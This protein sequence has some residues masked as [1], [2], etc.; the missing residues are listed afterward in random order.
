MQLKFVRSW[1]DQRDLKRFNRSGVD[2]SSN[3]LITN[4]EEDSMSERFRSLS[5]SKWDCKYHVMFVPKPRHGAIFGPTRRHLGRIFDALVRQKECHV[6]E[7]HLMPDHVHMHVA[8][9]PKHPVPSEARFSKGR[10]RSQRVSVSGARG[11]SDS[12]AHL[13]PDQIC[14]YSAMRRARMAQAGCSVK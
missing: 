5:P 4:D 1:F 9:P 10:V 14:Q 7:R 6:L 8:I 12:R 2:L 3:R 13:K 11:Y